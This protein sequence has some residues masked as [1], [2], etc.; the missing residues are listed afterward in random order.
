MIIYFG[1]EHKSWKLNDMA[2]VMFDVPWGLQ[3]QCSRPAETQYT[4]DIVYKEPAARKGELSKLQN[5]SQK[6]QERSQSQFSHIMYSTSYRWIN[7]RQMYL[8]YISN[9]VMSLMH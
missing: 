6:R 5:F 3:P 7:A 9:G 1:N 4:Y 2:R 8:R